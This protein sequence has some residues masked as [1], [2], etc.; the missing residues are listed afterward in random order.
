M[1]TAAQTLDRLLHEGR[2]DYVTIS[3]LIGRNAAYIQQFIHRG[4]PRKLDEADRKII[5][6]YLGVD[7]SLLGAPQQT[8][9]IGKGGKSKKNDPAIRLVPR[10][11][12]GASAGP[13][14]LDDDDT[15]SSYIGFEEK[16]LRTMSDN[17]ALMS[18]IQ[19]DGDSMTP[20]LN[21][22]DD[23]LVDRSDAGRA[24]REGVFVLRRDGTLLV[25]RLALSPASKSISVKSD[26]PN[27]PS[28]DN[29]DPNDVSVI[30]RVVWVG[31]RL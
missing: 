26:N 30:G 20:T 24:L 7:E 16:W 18:M 31:R 13:G 11:T 6:D 9:L 14:S 25:K 12:L 15:A 4:S 27:F 29:I 28:W 3:R 1:N 5:A 17:P 22:G 21:D 2:H 8:K 10:F 23:I 19:V